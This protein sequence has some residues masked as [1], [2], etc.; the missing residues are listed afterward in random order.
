VCRGTCVAD[1]DG[2]GERIEGLHDTRTGRR[3]KIALV[4]WVEIA[5]VWIYMIRQT[6]SNLRKDLEGGGEV[7]HRIALS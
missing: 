2:G 4:L 7:K 3:K 6:L 5:T 1:G